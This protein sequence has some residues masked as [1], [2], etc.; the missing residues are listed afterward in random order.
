MVKFVEITN[1]EA[2]LNA[3]LSTA[4]NADTWGKSIAY[5]GGEMVY[6]IPIEHLNADKTT[7]GDGETNPADQKREG[8]YGVVRNHWYRITVDSLVKM[9]HGIFNPGDGSEENPGEPIIPDEPEDPTYY[10]GAKINI[11]SWKIV[12]QSAG[13]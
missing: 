9:G 13:I 2:D 4:Q 5:T 8:Y 3:V 10:L 1:A 6:T 11:L 7:L 12:N